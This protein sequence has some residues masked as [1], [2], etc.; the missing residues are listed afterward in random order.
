MSEAPELLSAQTAEQQQAWAAVNAALGRLSL[1][2]GI[3]PDSLNEPAGAAIEA[4]DTAAGPTHLHGLWRQFL[5]TQ[6]TSMLAVDFFH[7]DCAMTLRRLY[8]LF[9]LEVGDRSLHILGVTARPDGPW[10][11]QQ[12]RNLVIDLA[13][14]VGRFRFSSATGPD[15]SRPRSTRCWPM[16]ASTWSR[17]R[18]AV[19]GRTACR[20]PRI[21][22]P[23][24]GH[25]PHADLRREAPPP[26]AG[27]VRRPLQHAATTSS[28]PAAPTTSGIACPPARPRQNPAP[29]SPRRAH[30][31]VRTRGLKPLIRDRGR[32]LEPDSLGWV[33]PAAAQAGQRP[34]A[35]GELA[36]ANRP[37]LAPPQPA[38]HLPDHPSPATRPAR[39]PDA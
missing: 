12:A 34:A 18:R 11:T 25:R 23:H 2:Y 26:R 39:R 15:S 31:R 6:A 35:R 17:S 14:H 21:D 33:R 30:Q 9:V 7:V 24:R 13:E 19:R 29:A 27:R 8:V 37:G 16:R 3:H 28:P 20:T 32:V 10:T 4:N 22:R 5:R 1:A 38:V 36:A